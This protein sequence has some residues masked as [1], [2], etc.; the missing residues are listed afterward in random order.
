[1]G[2]GL[3]GNRFNSSDWGGYL[4]H[5]LYPRRRVFIDGRADVYGD[6]FVDRYAE[7]AL[8]RPGW[9]GVLEEHAVGAVLVERESPLAVV[10]GDDPGW[11]E[12]Y[13]GP[14]ERLFVRRAIADGSAS[15][16]AVP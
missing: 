10:L 13:A 5:E 4:V 7:V 1:G 9:R 6:R 8:L 16:S 15:H 3:P 12:V 2:D 14:V 11:R